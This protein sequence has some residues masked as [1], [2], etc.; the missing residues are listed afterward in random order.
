[1]EPNYYHVG[2][3]SK[4]TTQLIAEP[5]PL[6][7]TIAK[8]SIYDE[9]CIECDLLTTWQCQTCE[10]AYCRKCFDKTHS[11]GK[12]IK[13]HIFTDSKDICQK[14]EKCY[15]Q[16]HEHLPFVNFCTKCLT[17]LCIT[18]TKTHDGKHIVKS[19]KSMVS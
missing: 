12:V 2:L 8:N 13:K 3:L 17:E 4:R 1:M 7:F 10:A 18:C 6:R 11:E 9:N 19:I 16:L 15:C 14:L 5:R